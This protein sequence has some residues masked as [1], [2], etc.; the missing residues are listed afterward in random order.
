MFSTIIQILI[1][2]SLMMLI[3]FSMM[4]L[5]FFDEH[6]LSGFST[7]LINICMP[8]LAIIALQNELSDSLLKKS[9]IFIV[10]SFI[11]YILLFV[12]TV[13]ICRL[14]KVELQDKAVWQLCM[15][16]PNMGF[17]GIPLIKAVYGLEAVFFVALNMF[18]ANML[19]FTGGIM[20]MQA[21][22]DKKPRLNKRLIARNPALLATI[23]GFMLF[24]MSVSLPKP[25]YNT[26]DMI[27][28]MTTPLSMIIIGAQLS[29]IRISELFNGK[30]N[31]A[32][33]LFKL[34]LA[35]V[36]TYLFCIFIL[37][38]QFLRNIMIL[39][40]ALP[41]GAATPALARQYGGNAPLASRFVFATTFLSL[42]TLPVVSL[43]L[44]YVNV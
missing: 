34:L 29:Q 10:G 11:I 19:I 36:A 17:M 39:I 2:F 20:L 13:L 23:L 37:P 44:D 15:T 21:G 9:M 28:S 5:A 43:F 14:L 6:M 38:D 12:L 22:K 1:S 25:I 3:G 35:P 8:C 31:F 42:L 27:G 30:K 24:I 33:V 41:S 18:V 4:K 32:P 40:F 26:L 7:L 16:Y